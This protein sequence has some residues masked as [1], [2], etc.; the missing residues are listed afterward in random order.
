[1]RKAGF[2]AVRCLRFHCVT[3][4]GS[5]SQLIPWLFTT[6][7]LRVLRFDRKK[8]PAAAPEAMDMSYRR[9]DTA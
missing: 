4:W 2:E 5:T 6:H 9:G 8:K 1:V 3:P 7:Q